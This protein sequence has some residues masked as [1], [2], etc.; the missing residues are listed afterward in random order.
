MDYSPNNVVL[1]RQLAQRIRAGDDP[2][3][4]SIALSAV[5]ASDAGNFAQQR[6][7]HRRLQSLNLASVGSLAPIKGATTISS[8]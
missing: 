5:A 6:S 1:D 7:G 8:R 2:R 3:Q 4:P